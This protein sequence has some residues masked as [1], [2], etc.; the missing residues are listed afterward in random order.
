MGER[1]RAVLAKHGSRKRKRAAPAAAPQAD[2]FG[3]LP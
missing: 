1:S 2:L 3:G